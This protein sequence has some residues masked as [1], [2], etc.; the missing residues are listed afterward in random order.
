VRAVRLGALLGAGPV[1][2]HPGAPARRGRPHPV[3]PRRAGRGRGGRR[4][5]A[6]R[7]GRGVNPRRSLRWSAAGAAAGGAPQDSGGEG[8]LRARPHRGGVHH[9]GRRG[10]KHPT[11]TGASRAEHPGRRPR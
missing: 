10:R 9:R 5:S 1:H 4:A 7:P 6:G 8:V 3:D 2:R 11:R